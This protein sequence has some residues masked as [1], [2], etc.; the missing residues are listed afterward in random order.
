M[1]EYPLSS[2]EDIPMRPVGVPPIELEF[3]KHVMG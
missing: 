3:G 1:D 2:P